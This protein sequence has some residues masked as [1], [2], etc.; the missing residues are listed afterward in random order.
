V[1]YV[2]GTFAKNYDS[3]DAVN[4]GRANFGVNPS[5]AMKKMIGLLPL[6]LHYFI[7]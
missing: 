7:V 6:E 1:D 5:L 3:A 4:Y 2:G